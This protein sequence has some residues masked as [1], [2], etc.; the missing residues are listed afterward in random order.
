MALTRPKYSQIY[1]TDW[2]QSAEVATTGS[3][4]GNLTVGNSQPSSLDGVSLQTGYR[5]LVKDQ[6]NGWDNGLYIVANVGTGSNGWW[7]RTLDANQNGFV[8]AGLTVTVV[9]GSVNGGREFRLTTPD[10]I[11]LGVTSL[12]FI[13][14][15]SA[16]QAGGANTQV[17][18]ND[19]SIINGTAGFTFN[20]YSNAVVMSGTLTVGNVTNQGSETITGNLSAANIIISGAGQFSGIYNENTTT[21]GVFVGNAGSGTPSP[22][23]GFFNGNSTQNWQ[24]DNYFGTFRW[25]TPGVT[26]M[27]IDGTGN[28]TVYGNIL[29]SANVTYNLGSPT[30]RFKTGYFSSNTIDLGGSQ[31]SVDPVNGFSFSVGGGTPTTI[32]ANGASTSNTFTAPQVTFSSTTNSVPYSLG[33]GAVYVAGGMSIAKDVW[34]SGSLYAGNLISTVANILTST[35]SLI[36]LQNANVYPYNYSIGFYGHFVGGP[37]NVYAHTAFVRNYTD[38]AWYLISNIAEP[39]VNGNINVTDSNRI[40]DTLNTGTHNVNGFLNVTGNILSTGAIHNSLTVNG[41]ITTQVLNSTGNVLGTSATY[42]NVVVNSG[43]VNAFGGYFVGNGYFL[44]GLVT[45]I[46]NQIYSGASNVTATSNYINV[47]VNGSNVFSFGA[48]ALSTS[49]Y[50]NTTGNISA[51]IANFGNASIAGGTHTGINA[52]SPAGNANVTLGSLTNQWSTIYGKATTAQYADLAEIYTSDSK[53][54]PGTVVIFGGDSEV[55]ISTSGHDPRIAGVVST[56][57]A[58]LMNSTE[59]GV[60]VALTGRVPCRVLGPV[61]KGDRL[62]ASD[63]PGVAQVLDIIHYQPGCIIGKALEPVETAE[64]STIEVV[65][66][67]L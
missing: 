25:Y 6:T 37:A 16:A 19:A 29:P 45:P 4:V 39:T 66:G 42:N 12:T 26:R 47:A 35:D 54:A 22:R 23:V 57:P 11:T 58:Y 62:V 67:R 20:K 61:A 40:F 50:I 55:T 3:D 18:F 1:D 48:A 49:T 30:L 28:L 60:E 14:P 15:Y 7:K 21:S 13:N 53:Y 9:L 63:I 44:T 2:K 32:S 27:S 10:P 5:I 43:N 31:I 24:I 52:I 65:V 38:N 64:I 46:P 59:S 17:Q 34:V 56:N 8:T 36:Y 51:A 41:T 33:S